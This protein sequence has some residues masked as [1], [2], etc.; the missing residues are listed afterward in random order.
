MLDS[1]NRVN[2][3]YYPHT[4]FEE[5]KYEIKRNKMENLLNDD[6][7]PSSFDNET[8]SESD[9]DTVINLIM[10]QTMNNLLKIKTIF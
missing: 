2:K 3:K 7:D 1:V 9:N 4:L 8:D 5:Y 6:L 10:R